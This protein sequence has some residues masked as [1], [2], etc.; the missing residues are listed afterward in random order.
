MSEPAV[1][2]ARYSTNKQTEASI[3]AQIRA[4]QEYAAS[5]GLVVIST[6]SDEAVSGKGSKTLSRRNYQKMLRDAEK[7]TFRTI[8]IHQY[9]RIARNLGEHVNL[10][11]KLKDL[12]VNLIAVAQDFGSGKEA[13]IMRA[14]MWSLSEYYL[15]NLAC[16]VRK[17]LRETALQA[18]HN[19]GVAPFGYDVVDQRYVINE[20]E[21]CFVRKIFD[22][23]QRLDGFT[24]I[25]KEMEACGVRGKRGKPIRYTQVYEM[26]RNEK[27]TGVY[28]YSPEEEKD[29]TKRREKPNAIRIEGAI[30]AII[31]KEQFSEVQKIM[32]E[33]KQ[34]GA[35]SDYLCGGLVYCGSCGS[36]MHG[37]TSKR[38]GHEYRYF[39][40]SGRCGAPVARMEDVEHAAVSYLKEIL[41]PEN[42]EKIAAALRIYRAG[43][44]RRAD[45]F[46]QALSKRI[47]EKQSQYD[48]LMRNLST[49]ALPPEVVSDIGAQMQSIKAEISALETTEPPEDLTGKQVN[50]WLESLKSS[51]DEKAI[52][53][54]ID[55]IEVTQKTD[56]NIT[57]TLKSVLSENG[58]GGMQHILPQILYTFH[59]GYSK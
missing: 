15:D 58:C 8:L 21:A 7:G 51:P 52:R 6:Y 24:D 14:L 19:G 3:E 40:C 11:I 22:S 5:H 16:E 46:R 31:S 28:L 53:L 26:L 59:I 32:N 18:M 43:E 54:L 2:Y 48:A 27:Y 38:K 23:A 55:R 45:E 30:P 33:R 44:G 9:D 35:K 47:Q 42:Q 25:L 57:S 29:R 39:V 36:K 50:N 49:V 1:I 34:S 12:G 56:I 20:L 41:S 10:E 4:C 17:G 37:M 13:K